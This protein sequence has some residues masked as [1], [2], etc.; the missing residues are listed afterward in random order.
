MQPGELSSPAVSQVTVAHRC[1]EWSTQH[2]R[3]VRPPRSQVGK[4]FGVRWL[5]CCLPSSD[6]MFP[7]PLIAPCH[8]Q[9]KTVAGDSDTLADIGTTSS[10]RAAFKTGPSWQQLP[11]V[12]GRM[13]LGARTLDLSH[14]HLKLGTFTRRPPLP[15]WILPL[16]TSAQADAAIAAARRSVKDLSCP[17]EELAAAL[18]K[19]TDAERVANECAA[20]LKQKGEKGEAS[21]AHMHA[22]AV[23]AALTERHA[24]ME[25]SVKG[26]ERELDALGA[27]WPLVPSSIKRITAGSI[28]RNTA[29]HLLWRCGVQGVQRAHARGWPAFAPSPMATERACRAASHRMSTC[30]AS[31]RWRARYWRA[32]ATASS[33]SH[34]LHWLFTYVDNKLRAA[35]DQ[36]CAPSF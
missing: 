23:H 6:A 5:G 9:R 4:F 32:G 19:T 25:A 1:C 30:S 22:K 36:D 3:V 24:A 26:I 21:A 16:I 18:I 20:K 35:A 13:A 17:R 31:T 10:P 11:A 8:L 28:N 2:A 15:S 29:I 27:V 7:P 14:L 12:M 33:S 34:T